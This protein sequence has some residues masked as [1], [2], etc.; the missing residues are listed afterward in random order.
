MKSIKIF[1]AA[2]LMTCFFSACEN[3]MDINDI[4]AGT[5]TKADSVLPAKHHPF[6][7]EQVAEWNKTVPRV[8]HR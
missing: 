5:P 1:L 8:Y 4:V 7:A 2:F 6:S 3:H